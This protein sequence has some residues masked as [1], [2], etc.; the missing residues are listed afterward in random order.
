MKPNSRVLITD[1]HRGNALAV[2]RSLGRQGMQ[3]TAASP[4]PSALGFHSKHVKNKLVHKDPTSNPNDYADSI[5]N[6]VIAEKIDLVIPVTDEAII[7]LIESA[8]KFPRHCRIAM[9]ESTAFKIASDKLQ[10]VDM[11]KRLGVPVPNTSFVT[12][13]EEAL[14]VVQEF[15]WPIVLKPQSSRVYRDGQSIQSCKVDYARNEEELVVKMREIN[16]PVLLQ[17]FV[18]GDGHGV[19][20]LMHQGRPLAAFQHHRLHEVPVVGGVSSLRESVELDDDLYRHALAMLTE[21]NWTGLAM[22]EFKVGPTGKAWLME[23]NG[24]IWGSIP[25]AV[26]SGMDFPAQLADL[27]LT[28]PPTS[29]RGVNT[30]YHRNVR[31][32]N[33]Q[34]EITWILS[35]LLRRKQ[36]AFAKFPGRI[37]AF[38]ALF[39]FFNPRCRDDILAWDDFSPGL[40]L[41]WLI[42]KNLFRKLSSN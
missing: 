30:N 31:S 5:L 28:G 14:K 24:R 15:D 34:L 32:R 25:L 21:L 3:V 26:H 42:V 6:T 8:E 13:S 18:S 2:I 19:E 12:S 10:T 39:T 7:P 38:T 37:G 4:D 17:E 1:A 29:D 16:S 41:P 27:Y 22:V 35:V 9:P 40:R 36:H 11:A 20:I 23:I 33:S